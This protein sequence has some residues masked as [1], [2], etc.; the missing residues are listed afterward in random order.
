MESQCSVAGG[1]RPG[2]GRGAFL[3]WCWRAR[4]PGR[5]GLVRATLREGDRPVTG[6]F[7]SIFFLFTYLLIHC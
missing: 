2:T 1:L 6:P 3:R 4:V 5:L 7:L